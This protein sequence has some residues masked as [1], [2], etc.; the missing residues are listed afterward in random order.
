MPQR[1][2]NLKPKSSVF[3]TWQIEMKQGFLCRLLNKGQCSSD[4]IVSRITYHCYGFSHVENIGWLSAL[5]IDLSRNYPQVF[6]HMA[7]AMSQWNVITQ[8]GACL[9]RTVVKGNG[10]GSNHISMVI[11]GLYRWL[12]AEEYD[13]PNASALK[14]LQ[15][16]ATSSI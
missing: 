7:S 16:C 10:V 3:E 14:L 11:W 12:S 9:I 2:E 5:S 4:Q 6:W 15:S 1:S 13:Y 8:F